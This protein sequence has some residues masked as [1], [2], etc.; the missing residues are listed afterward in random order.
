MIVTD[1]IF[2]DPNEPANGTADRRYLPIGPAATAR[3]LYTAKQYGDAV[4]ALTDFVASGK[5]T[6]SISAFY[7]RLTM[8]A[9]DNNKFAWWMCHADDSVKSYTTVVEGSSKLDRP[10]ES[11]TWNLF[12]AFHRNAS[13]DEIQT[14]NQDRTKLFE[15]SYAFPNQSERL[16]GLAISDFESPEIDLAPSSPLRLAPSGSRKLSD[17]PQPEFE[18]VAPQIGLNHTCQVASKPQPFRFA[19]H[20]SLGGALQSVTSIATAIQT[21]TSPKAVVILRG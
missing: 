12:A 19:L 13:Q 6:P 2:D 15:S 20:Q 14:L 8:E 11:I 3:M 5:S 7:G 16:C 21:C 17:H 9:Q 4:D 10:L 1:A 18:N